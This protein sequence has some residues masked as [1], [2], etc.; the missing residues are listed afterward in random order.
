MKI[1]LAAF[2]L[3]LSVIQTAIAQN[4]T[5]PPLHPTFAAIVV[6]NLDTSLHWYQDKLRLRLL[7]R[8][9]APERG[10]R[11]A[12]LTGEGLQIELVEVSRSLTYAQIVENQPKGT[13]PRGFFKI[14]FTVSN[15]DIWHMHLKK[16]G[17]KFEGRRVKD[18]VSGKEMF[19]VTDPDGN[20]IQ[21]FEN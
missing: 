7:N 1:K 12:N 16:R 6:G 3:F 20:L 19:L 5:L 8:T 11:Q 18:P 2:W 14:G 4:D 17:A 10:F 15:L 21:F 13:E 9:D